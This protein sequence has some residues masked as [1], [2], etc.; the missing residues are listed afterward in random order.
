MAISHMVATIVAV[1]FDAS[2]TVARNIDGFRLQVEVLWAMKGDA[3]IFFRAAFIEVGLISAISVI[4]KN[5]VGIPTHICGWTIVHSTIAI[6]P[7]ACIQVLD[8]T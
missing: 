5:V 1:L 2:P 6:F 8:C 7:C 3:Q 4:A